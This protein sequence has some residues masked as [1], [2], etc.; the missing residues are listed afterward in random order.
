MGDKGQ[1][2]DQGRQGFAAHDE[3]D[4][5]SRR[6]IGSIDISHGDGPWDARAKTPTGHFPDFFSV[7]VDFC[8]FAGNRLVLRAYAN[9]L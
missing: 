7:G 4:L 5:G 9:P 3:F 8:G 1:I 6:R 2:D